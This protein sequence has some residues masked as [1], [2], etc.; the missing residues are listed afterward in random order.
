MQVI[1]I[2]EVSERTHRQLPGLKRLARFLSMKDQVIEI[3]AR[4]SCEGVLS[5]PS[6]FSDVGFAVCVKN[7]FSEHT[8]IFGVCNYLKFVDDDKCFYIIQHHSFLAAIVIPDLGVMIFWQSIFSKRCNE[9]LSDLSG[10]SQKDMNKKPAKLLGFVNGYSRPYHYFYDRLP[11]ALELNEE[12]PEV[13]FHDVAGGCY[14]SLSNRSPVSI[15]ELNQKSFES[16][17][18]Y[19][20]PSKS[21]RRAS[22]VESSRRILTFCNQSAF[23]DDSN[24]SEATSDL[25][26]KFVVWI[27]LCSEKRKWPER[28]DVVA[29]IVNYISS[30][31]DDA[32]FLFDG[33]TSTVEDDI[34]VFRREKCGKDLESLATVLQ[35]VDVPVDYIDLIG[36]GARRKILMSQ[37][38]D[39]FFTGALTDSMW[40]AH[41]GRK[42][43]LAY[44]ARIASTVIH[45]HPRTC[46]IPDSMVMDLDDGNENWARKGYSISPDDAFRSFKDLF[47]REFT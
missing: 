3:I 7:L 14:L 17:G 2:K 16:G 34:E 25:S 31:K 8:N 11:Y 33:M 12:F 38:V 35:G 44:S 28:E 4:M 24:P 46:F 36:A 39:I 29:R 10:F 18:V 45:D 42:K 22:G 6:V 47:D 27:G 5:L 30:R 9:V 13:P 20:I 40:P 43:G 19:L 26:T 32:V 1:S 21:G 15:E 23:K 37:F 41:F